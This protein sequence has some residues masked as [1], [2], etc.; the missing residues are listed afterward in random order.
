MRV[1]L[2][3]LVAASVAAMSLSAS[4]MLAAEAADA[5]PA[6]DNAPQMTPDASAQSSD[7]GVGRWLDIN[8]LSFALRFRGITDSNGVYSTSQGQQRS[9]IDGR[10]KFDRDGK[11]SIGFHVSSGRYFN[12]AY[13]DFIGGASNF[14]KQEAAFDMTQLIGFGRAYA[15]SPSFD[16]TSGGW[17]MFVRELYFSAKPVDGV[18]LQYGG[19]GINHGVNTEMTS[20]DDD[21]YL[22][23]E[24]LT[25]RRPQNLFFDEVG[26]TYAYLGDIFSPNLFTRGNRF[27]QSNYHQFLVRKKLGSRLEFSTD[28]TKYFASTMREAALLRT[29]E[30]KV[31][32]S[33]RVEAY[34]RL[35]DV[36]QFGYLYPSGNGYAFTA[37]KTINKRF[38]LQAGVA[39]IDYYYSYTINLPVFA[40]FG[41]ALNGDS[42]GEGR[43]FF[44]RP[45]IKL[46]NYLSLFGF[47]SHTFDYEPPYPHMLWNKQALNAGILFDIKELV[48][49]KWL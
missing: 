38:N 49:K 36:V 24:R 14:Q 29:P 25:L 41:F 39:D 13:A 23:G 7:E 37:D 22:V 17:A 27:E 42:I 47:Y 44:V 18:E 43:R 1:K 3:L 11:Y 16:S 8:T 33:V 19:I 30:T 35:N 40:D 28:Y 21:G 2:F 12:W 45:T 15:A 34:Q 32:D 10:F 6:A 26:V 9:L 48:P 4:R 20:F 5:N 46:T 31:L